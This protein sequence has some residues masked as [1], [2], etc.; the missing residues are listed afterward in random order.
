M[1]GIIGLVKIRYVTAHTGIGRVAKT[2]GMAGLTV[3]GNKPVGIPEHVELIVDVKSR[4]APAG[5]CGVTGRT[6]GGKVQITL[7]RIRRL[8]VI[9]AVTIQTNGGSAFES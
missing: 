1:I 6:I 4:R 7:L 8:I 9:R 2:L 3:V 5:S